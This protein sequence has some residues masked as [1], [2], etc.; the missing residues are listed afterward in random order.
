MDDD[1]IIIDLSPS[2]QHLQNDNQHDEN[3]AQNQTDFPSSKKEIRMAKKGPMHSTRLYVSLSFFD[4][5]S[6]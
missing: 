1:G 4:H 2:E 6:I 5:H 3:L